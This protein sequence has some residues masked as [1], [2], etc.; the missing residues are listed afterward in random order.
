MTNPMTQAILRKINN[1]ALAA[2]VEQWD[3]VE[4]LVVRVFRAG[5]VLPEDESVYTALR[6]SL[7]ERF[8]RWQAQL[9]PYW[10][11]TS[12]KGDLVQ[13]DPFL[14][15][16]SIESADGFVGDW[17]AMQHLP[18]AR[19]ALNNFLIDQIEL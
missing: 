16:L 8:P 15:I 14:R 9:Q 17:N 6:S 4:V 1:P 2:F 10:G 5:V 13:R 18:A 3:E 11:V 19:E 12:I 7:L